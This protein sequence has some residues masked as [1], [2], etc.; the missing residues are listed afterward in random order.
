MSCSAL[1]TTISAAARMC[2]IS[3]DESKKEKQI[4]DHALSQRGFG[5]STPSEAERKWATLSNT[6]HR[7]RRESRQRALSNTRHR[8]RRESRQRATHEPRREHTRARRHSVVRHRSSNQENK[9]GNNGAYSIM[10]GAGTALQKEKGSRS[11]GMQRARTESASK[12]S[13]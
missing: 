6:R 9:G 11:Q 10:L 3:R 13:T 2:P 7:R 4:G 12:E 5:L 8:R 1:V